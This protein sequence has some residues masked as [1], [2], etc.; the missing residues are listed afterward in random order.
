MSFLVLQDKNSRSLKDVGT[1]LILS[2]CLLTRERPILSLNE[3]VMLLFRSFSVALISSITFNHS[4]GRK[5]GSG[6]NVQLFEVLVYQ[7]VES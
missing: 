4:N 3:D 6:A 5:K 1:L 7:G 2:C